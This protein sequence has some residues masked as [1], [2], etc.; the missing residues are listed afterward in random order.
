MLA[1]PYFRQRYDTSI[2]RR[3][4]PSLGERPPTLGSS[5]VRELGGRLLDVTKPTRSL[6]ALGELID[7][8]PILNAFDSVASQVAWGAAE[9]KADRLGLKGAERDA[10]VAREAERAVRRTQNS[11]SPLDMSGIAARARGSLLS[12][13]LQFTSDA[14]KSWN[15]LW[16]AWYRGDASF[17][18]ALV[19]VAL[20]AAFAAAVSAV[21]AEL[22]DD[23][24]RKNDQALSE[25]F[26]R[27]F[28]REMAGLPY[29]GPDAASVLESAF[30]LAVLG[31]GQAPEMV[32]QRLFETPMLSVIREA[33]IGFGKFM[34]AA[35]AEG[36]FKTGPRRGQSKRAAYA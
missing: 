25:R 17:R 21:W 8:I 2:F 13:F 18:R 20:N 15:L 23:D 16:S 30:D 22:V 29:G 1:S 6:G 33:L 34:Q 9:A 26:A 32:A 19:G 7:K 4:T 11:S 10:F 36:R 12:P 35:G 5:S 28:M 31:R 24:D 27:H 14:N 3:V